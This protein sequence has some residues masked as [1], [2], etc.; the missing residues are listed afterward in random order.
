MASDLTTGNI[1][2]NIV[3]VA[4][5]LH[6]GQALPRDTLRAL[7]NHLHSRDVRFSAET[8]SGASTLLFSHLSTNHK[9]FAKG[10][11]DGIVERIKSSSFLGPGAL[12]FIDGPTQQ[13]LPRHTF[14]NKLQAVLLDGPHA[15]PFPDLEYYFLYPHLE[16][17]GL[18]VLD[19]VH[20]R[21]VHNLFKLLRA[22]EMF[23][24]NEVVNR[25]AFFTRT[26]AATFDPLG[27][28]WE[29]QSYNRS[30]L[31]R[32]SWSQRLRESLPESARRVARHFM[33]HFRAVASGPRGSIHIN[34]P[35][36]GSVVGSNGETSGTASIPKDA[37]LWLLARRADQDG[38]WPQGGGPVCVAKGRWSCQVQYGGPRDAGHAFEV[39]AAIVSPAIHRHWLDWIG[40]TAGAEVLAPVHLLPNTTSAQS[41]L[42]V[43]K[44]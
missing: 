42:Q 44:R 17:G 18:L 5:V 14:P 37:H 13:T 4:A 1:V 36:S 12:E 34:H 15:Y 2:D 11:V 21:T 30:T 3:E 26:D 24:L 32:F 25:T 9:V 10:G 43:R 20:I 38:W 19:D 27:D 31:L 6:P 22:D 23:E 7:A 28:G 41:L 29:E 8:G 39:L 40:Q 16:P 35:E 33:R